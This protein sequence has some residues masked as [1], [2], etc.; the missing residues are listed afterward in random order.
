[1][2]TI[3]LI[4]LVLFG[5]LGQ[6]LH[7][8]VS[9][10]V[11]EIK[12]DGA[13]TQTPQGE[14]WM[15]V[16][17]TGHD[18]HDPSVNTVAIREIGFNGSSN[19]VTVKIPAEVSFV[20]ELSSSETYKVTATEG[21]NTLIKSEKIQDIILP[22][23]LTTIN[24]GSFQHVKTATNFDA[25]GLP[26]TLNAIGLRCF[27]GATVSKFYFLNG[28]DNGFSLDTR[29]TYGGSV[30][31]KCGPAIYKDNGQTLVLLAPGYG[32][33][34]ETTA[35]NVHG[36]GNIINGRDYL[37]ENTITKIE[38]TAIN[39]VTFLRGLRIPS[40]V[41][42]IKLGS[43]V[44]DGSI[45]ASGTYFTYG[46]TEEEMTSTSKYFTNG[47]VLFHYN[48]SADSRVLVA[49]PI[50]Y[51]DIWTV[52]SNYVIEG[53]TEFTVRLRGNIYK[54]ITLNN[55]EA[56][57]STW[58]GNK[59][60]LKPYK[61]IGGE[62]V[63]A[64]HL[65]NFYQTHNDVW[66]NKALLTAD[67]KQSFVEQLI[68]MGATYIDG[69][70][71]EVAVTKD[72]IDDAWTDIYI[73]S[74]TIPTLGWKDFEFKVPSGVT[75]IASDAFKSIKYIKEIDLGPT[76]VTVNNYAISQMGGLKKVDIEAHTTDI[77]EG[78]IVECSGIEQFWVDP[79]NTVYTH[80]IA[81][82]NN[83]NNPHYGVL[84]T[85]D[86]NNL[87]LYPNGK[88]PQ[89][90]SYTIWNGTKII[91]KQAFKGNKA[92]TEVTIPGSVEEIHEEAFRRFAI[93]TYGNPT[94]EFI[95]HTATINFASNG[96]LSLIAMNAFKESYF[97][98]VT[99][100][101]SVQ[102]IQN[103]AFEAMPELTKVTFANNNNMGN[104]VTQNS[105][106]IEGKPVQLTT[107]GLGIATFRNNPKLTEVTFGS[108]DK[109]TTLTTNSFSADSALTKV[110]L[111]TSLEAIGPNALQAAG[112][113]YT[114]NND[115]DNTLDINLSALTNLKEIGSYG[116][117]SSNIGKVINLNN[118]KLTTIGAQAFDHC[119][120]MTQILLPKQ[121][122]HVEYGAF[123]FCTR[124]EAIDVVYDENETGGKGVCAYISIDG[125]LCSSDKQG[126]HTFPGGKHDTDYAL[127]PYITTV[128]PYAFYACQNLKSI[129]FPKTVTEIGRRALAK[130]TS[131]ESISFMGANPDEVIKLD[132]ENTFRVTSSD[133][134]ETPA[135]SAITINVRK[136]WSDEWYRRYQA[137]QTTEENPLV[138]YAAR[139]KE[140]N[141]SFY[142][143]EVNG[144]TNYDRDLEFFQLSDT[145]VGVVGMK[146]S[147][148]NNSVL[149][150][151]VIIN[152]IVN[153]PTDHQVIRGNALITEAKTNL[154]VKAI[155]DFAFAETSRLNTVIVLPEI[156]Y[157]GAK[158]FTGAA[159][160]D[161][162]FLAGNTKAPAFMSETLQM[163]GTYF[164][165]E[166]EGGK[167]TGYNLA[168]RTD[169]DFY[170]FNN[171]IG[172][173]KKVKIYCRKSIA[174]TF[175][176]Y[177]RINQTITLKEG[178]ATRSHQ[179]V[180]DYRVPRGTSGKLATICYPFGVQM[181]EKTGE[182]ADNDIKAFIPLEYK[183]N[184][185][186]KLILVRARSID[187]GYVPA[188]NAVLLHSKAGDV[189]AFDSESDQE[190]GKTE[191][192]SAGYFLISEADAHEDIYFD[193]PTLNDNIGE[194]KKYQKV[195]IGTVE[196]TKVNPANAT[197]F[198]ITKNGGYTKLTKEQE[199]PY[200]L[201]FLQFI[202][203][204][205]QGKQLKFTFDWDDDD[206]E[207]GETT[208]ID[209]LNINANDEKAVY[210]N[211]QGQRVEN[212]KHGVYIVN[213]KKV[214]LK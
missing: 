94:G 124:L 204:E 192:A 152:P 123:T 99:I 96:N 136:D 74:A 101:G 157:I 59:G 112:G 29:S 84:Y 4:A 151:S 163:D 168:Y 196:H 122:W 67:Q 21:W 130:C 50:K 3:R 181:P 90:T 166:V 179:P 45:I 10:D 134:D 71:A 158:A 12:F 131:L 32:K 92:L 173:G 98:E 138:F 18:I 27:E 64:R 162:V 139:F 155:L 125:M 210:Y 177:A 183:K 111:P 115:A 48:S 103:N 83:E 198:Y 105:V 51:T 76:T 5:V 72:N 31:D 121:L 205:Y 78:A 33:N 9:S 214:V 52:E 175:K 55:Y 91:E 95:H 102:T 148:E 129:V 199:F 85:K 28:N 195:M 38:N 133:N 126:L 147:E 6:N 54:T 174:E 170:P 185:D 65:D 87:K 17:I 89:P 93:D 118:G 203:N 75:S 169:K 77:K 206:D 120:K 97:T 63:V 211:L 104:A 15:N 142:V 36:D 57:Y 164:Q 208:G 119:Q 135:S 58:N 82:S 194:G 167:T 197:Y 154:Q 143:R 182:Y 8:Q 127:L 61:T 188:Y 1:M 145:E 16:Q 213:G 184:D 200:F 35:D 114:F 73:K 26:K 88:G 30:S 79:A 56:P 49:V 69:N 172:S 109:L 37:I 20:G 187:N 11:R 24:N 137:G 144:G 108:M 41:T 165:A 212:P 153:S 39:N 140:V 106:D 193:D 150:R 46:D 80:D 7:A 146:K 2:K 180:V 60:Y 13:G 171:T 86:G 34:Y 23:G 178:T 66:L 43:S 70:G 62:T 25:I 176:N 81:S 117:A 202:G 160:I 161:R 53:T 42:D 190:L 110:V 201:G 191:E 189:A 22:E 68:D 156:D 19:N 207:G 149:R 128:A 44:G 186:D 132:Y 100:P 107:S 40:S 209:D 116:L 47:G 159:D 14:F 141:P 113:K